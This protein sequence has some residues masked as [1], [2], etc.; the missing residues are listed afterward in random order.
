M[1]NFSKKFKVLIFFSEENT[2]NIIKVGS[3]LEPNYN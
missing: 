3:F 1:E 2:E